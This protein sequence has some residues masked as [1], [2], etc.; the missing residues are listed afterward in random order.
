MAVKTTTLDLLAEELHAGAL[1]ASEDD[2]AADAKL[3]PRTETLIREA[4]AVVADIL[5]MLS[6]AFAETA[7]AVGRRGHEGTGED[8]RAYL[9]LHGTTVDALRQIHEAIDKYRGPAGGR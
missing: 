1:A 5:R 8:V 6:D 2:S 4:P 9:E 7:E 3:P